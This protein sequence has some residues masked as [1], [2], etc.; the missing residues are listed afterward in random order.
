MEA[1]GHVGAGAASTAPRNIPEIVAS[2]RHKLVRLS[3]TGT[4]RS[5]LKRDDRF[6]ILQSAA[7]RL[8]TLL[9]SQASAY[10]PDLRP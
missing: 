8:A 7:E 4:H 6:S 9:A 10:Q 1:D 5:A 2:S 3:S